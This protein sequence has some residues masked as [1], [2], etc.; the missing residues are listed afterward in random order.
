MAWTATPPREAGYY[1]ISIGGS[2][3]IWELTVTGEWY[4]HGDE[5]VQYPRTY[6][7]FWD[8]PILPPES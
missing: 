4:M 1:W 2:I 8:Q 7:L 5:T 6:Y 3:E